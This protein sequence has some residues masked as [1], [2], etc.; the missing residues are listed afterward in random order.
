M[1]P[2]CYGLL[3]SQVPAG[4]PCPF[5]WKLNGF[6]P[7]LCVVTGNRGSSSLSRALWGVGW[8][9]TVSD[10]PPFL[11]FSELLTALPRCGPPILLTT[12]IINTRHLHVKDFTEGLV[13]ERDYII[14]SG[15]KRNPTSRIP[16]RLFFWPFPTRRFF[17]I[18]PFSSQ[19]CC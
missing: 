1:T 14:V 13:M 7:I 4:S 15:R 3:V 8:C 10:S 9:L 19:P 2:G 18:S 17:P 5:R 6:K 12:H 16:L 11:S